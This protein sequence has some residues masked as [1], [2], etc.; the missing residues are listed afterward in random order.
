MVVQQRR[1][2]GIIF[3][4]DVDDDRSIYIITEGHV[5]IKKK[6]RAYQD[7]GT[8]TCVLDDN[9]HVV[10]NENPHVRLNPGDCFGESCLLY[11]DDD[12]E[13]KRNYSAIAATD[14]KLFMLNRVAIN[15]L[16]ETQ[17]EAFEKLKPFEQRRLEKM[18]KKAVDT[19]RAQGVAISDGTEPMQKSRS[20]DNHVLEGIQAVMSSSLEKMVRAHCNTQRALRRAHARLAPIV[21]GRGYVCMSAC[22]VYVAFTAKYRLMLHILPCALLRRRPLT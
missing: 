13:Y 19:L 16:R 8:W 14:V 2:E 10:Y 6:Q 15:H 1:E 21:D 17:P 12:A 5:D 20:L 3:E 7:D 22:F 9:G 18:H 4:E 11:L